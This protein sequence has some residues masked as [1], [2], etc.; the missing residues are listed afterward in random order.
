[1]SSKPVATPNGSLP[2]Q[3]PRLP[4]RPSASATSASHASAPRMLDSSALMGD[5]APRRNLPTANH[6]A[7]QIDFDQMSLTEGHGITTGLE[8]PSRCR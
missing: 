7:G 3:V 6:E 1:M 4:E 5:P 2:N 8:P